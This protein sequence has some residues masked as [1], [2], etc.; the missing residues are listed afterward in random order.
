MRIPEKS[1]LPI[2][3]ALQTLSID[4]ASIAAFHKAF[5][6]K[7]TT[8]PATFAARG[9]TGVFEIVNALQV[10]WRN[11]LHAT[12]TFIFNRPLKIP[13]T[14]TCQAQLKDSRI[15]AGML[16]LQFECQLMD[17]TQ[18][19]VFVTSKSLIMVRIDSSSPQS[20]APSLAE[21]IQPL[22]SLT[23]DLIDRNQIKDYCEASGD[24]NK[25][26]HDD[27]FAKQAGL[28]GIIAHGMLSMGLMARALEEW[29]FAPASSKQIEAKFKNIVVP[30]D[31]LR[32]ELLSQTTDEICFRL[33]NQRGFEILSGSLAL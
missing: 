15:R 13:S 27:T 30:N 17:E 25:I 19:Q 29:N 32:A 24:W 23:F 6:Q 21:K 10:D 1:E 16:W 5:R 31:L 4:E 8:V 11:L 3:A 2:R 33:V 14:L 28:P 12:Q 7:S 9:L 20:H 22:K 26:H 18:T